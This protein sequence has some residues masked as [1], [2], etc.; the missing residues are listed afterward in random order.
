M[1]IGVVYL[2]AVENSAAV[3]MCIHVPVLGSFGK[4]LGVEL[5]DHMVILSFKELSNCF[6]S[7]CTILQSHHNVQGFLFL[8]ILANTY[9]P[10]KFFF[11][12]T[13]LV[14]MK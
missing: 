1:N 4:Y 11:H 6:Y 9:F 3:S 12:Y 5:R 2:L 8:H 7:D 13:I 10:L 14:G